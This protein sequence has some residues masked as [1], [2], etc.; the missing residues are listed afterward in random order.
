MNKLIEFLK[1][2]Y[3]KNI[4]LM[5]DTGLRIFNLLNRSGVKY[6]KDLEEA[7]RVSK[8]VTKKGK[9]CLLSPATASYGF[10]KN[11]EERGKVFCELVK[12]EG[13]F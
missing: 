11:F 10:F 1:A 4:I 7:V 13:N 2:S 6:V 12:E 8:E 5:Y 3:V 9:S